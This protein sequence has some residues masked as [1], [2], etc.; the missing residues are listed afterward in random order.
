MDLLTHTE[1]K[2]VVETSGNYQSLLEQQRDHEVGHVLKKYAIID[3][4]ECGWVL[5]NAIYV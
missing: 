3:V 5:I 2:L 4:L 1:Q